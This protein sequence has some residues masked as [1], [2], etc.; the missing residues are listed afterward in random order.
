MKVVIDT[1]VLVSA[2][3][4]GGRADG[5]GRIVG[6]W[7]S[8]AIQPLVSEAIMSEYL[9]VLAYPKF[10]LTQAEIRHLLEHE[11]L[12]WFEPVD[13]PEGE[14]FIP[15]DP[16]DDKFIWCAVAGRAE[17]IV[18]GDPHLLTCVQAPVSIISPAE[19]LRKFALFS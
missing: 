3:L 7:T 19:L 9:R 14:A 4:F 15:D 5:P 18:S 17:L 12:P 1:N 2:L 16:Q 11:V 6:L 13:V 10:Q 8:G